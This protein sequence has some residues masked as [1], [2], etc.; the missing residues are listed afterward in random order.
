[1]GSRVAP[2][3]WLGQKHALDID[4]F[5]NA[6]SNLFTRLLFGC[7]V[8]KVESRY[9]FRQW[10]YD[11]LKPWQHYI[12]VA[13]DLSDLAE[14]VDWARAHD[15][16]C[17]EIAEAGRRLALTMTM[18]AVTAE[19]VGIIE[20]NWRHERSDAPHRTSKGPPAP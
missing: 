1:T 16:A 4:G 2:A 8:L 9:G 3:T 7:C 15:R 5:S 13:A 20:A 11:R 17:Q 14:R 12:P 18:S 10:Y 6:W 19:A